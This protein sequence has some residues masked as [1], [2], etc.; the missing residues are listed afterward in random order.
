MPRH[1]DPFYN[2]QRPNHLTKTLRPWTETA[3]S[4]QPPSEAPGRTELGLG[5]SRSSGQIF[6]DYEVRLSRNKN[7]DWIRDY[8]TPSLAKRAHL[9]NVGT[10][11]RSLASIAQSRVAAQ[12]RNL[13]PDH[14]YMIP[15]A[16]AEEIWH[17]ILDRYGSGY[18]IVCFMTASPLMCSLPD[19]LKAS[20]RGGHWHQPFR[21]Q[22]NLDSENIDICWTSDNPSWQSLI[23]SPPSLLRT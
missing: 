13:T 5:Y 22:T 6:V 23:T 8:R 12:M 7:S 17:D 10:G 19:E 20:M 14:F 4:G 16:M 3:P 1:P 9:A 2:H 15:W 18:L 21:T 11:A